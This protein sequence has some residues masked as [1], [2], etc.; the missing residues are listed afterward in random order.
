LGET[1]QAFKKDG[2]SINLEQTSHHP[3]TSNFYLNGPE[4]QY[5]MFGFAVFNANMTGV[6]SIRGW[7]EGK[8]IIKFKDGTIMTYT[9]PDMRIQGLIMG[10]RITNFSG[11][12]TIKDYQN[13][14]ECVV[15]LP[16]KV[17]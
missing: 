12:L 5:E 1:F 7:R 14:I 3:P 10:D 11:S 15:T 9:T 16:W 4:K 17:K 13:K 2:T 8:N 6:N